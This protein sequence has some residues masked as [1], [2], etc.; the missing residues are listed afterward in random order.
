MFTLWQLYFV[1]ML[2]KAEVDSSESSG[3]WEENCGLSVARLFGAL[4]CEN[5]LIFV[6]QFWVALML[7]SLS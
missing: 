4:N 1:I 7:D 5:V 2:Q 3:W 6:R